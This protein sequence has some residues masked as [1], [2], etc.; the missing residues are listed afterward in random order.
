[1]PGY[2]GKKRKF[3]HTKAIL[4]DGDDSFLTQLPDRCRKAEE[5]DAPENGLI[6]IEEH[7]RPLY[8]AGQI[9]GHCFEYAYRM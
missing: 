6:K 1:M 4:H 2:F 5:I 9:T 8:E 7:I 3:S